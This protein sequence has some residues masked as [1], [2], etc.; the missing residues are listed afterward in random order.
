M[1]RLI[2]VMLYG[3]SPADPIALAV[4]AFVLVAVTALA[5]MIPARRATAVDPI[6]VL[7]YQ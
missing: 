6:E 7:R 2:G 4:A 3:V 1:T 5:S